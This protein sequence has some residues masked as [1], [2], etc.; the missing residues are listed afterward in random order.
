MQTKKKNIRFSVVKKAMITLLH[1]AP[2]SF[3][4]FNSFY[5]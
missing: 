1:L 4:V 3:Q 5:L 2:S